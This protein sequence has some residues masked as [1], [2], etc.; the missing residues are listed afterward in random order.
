MTAY[1]AHVLEHYRA[2]HNRRAMPEAT[3]QHKADNPLCGDEV[4]VH[5]RVAD[6]VVVDAS[7]EGVGCAVSVAAA[8]LLTKRWNGAPVA[9]VQ[10][11]TREEV[12]AL[13]DAPLNPTRKRCASLAW[14]AAQAALQ[15]DPSA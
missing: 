7:W 15:S 11:M 10:A 2:P 8:S 4:T 14:E 12:L 13:V 3:H 5:L 6:G 9:E 1:P